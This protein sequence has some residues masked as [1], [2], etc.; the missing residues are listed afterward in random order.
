MKAVFLHLG[1]VLWNRT[2]NKYKPLRR[3]LI[4]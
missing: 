1:T 2:T 3:L 4:I